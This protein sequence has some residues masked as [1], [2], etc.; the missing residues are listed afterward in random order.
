MAKDSKEDTAVLEVVLD[1]SRWNNTWQW[2]F[3]SCFSHI[4]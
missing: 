1:S 4:I 3:S 2:Q